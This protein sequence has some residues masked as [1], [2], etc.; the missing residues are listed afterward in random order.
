[1]CGFLC[2]KSAALFCVHYDIKPEN[3]PLHD[4]GGTMVAKISDFGTVVPIGN[5]QRT[6]TLVYST[7][8][9]VES[10][11][12]PARDLFA[13]VLIIYEMCKWYE[14]PLRIA[15]VGERNEHLHPDTIK[16][17]DGAFSQI[18]M[19]QMFPSAGEAVTLCRY[20]QNGPGVCSA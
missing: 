17:L 16:T 5:Q 14:S 11:A 4:E 2:L 18:A 10:P 8:E 13:F 6:C 12:A 15:Y 7:A 9:M 19:Q 3:I 1:M 20:T